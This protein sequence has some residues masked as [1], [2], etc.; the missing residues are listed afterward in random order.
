MARKKSITEAAKN[1]IPIARHLKRKQES[2]LSWADHAINGGIEFEVQL[3]SDDDQV[4]R[5]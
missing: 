1:V 3:V 4:H 2:E 5:R